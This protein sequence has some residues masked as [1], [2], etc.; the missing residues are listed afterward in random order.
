MNFGEKKTKVMGIS[1]QPS[2][3]QIVA[4]QKHPE[5][6]KYFNCLG[7]VVRKLLHVEVNSDC[8]S[9]SSIQEEEEESFN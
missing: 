3:V 4:G 6:V 8:Q 5:N 1:R 7:N 2:P 9:K